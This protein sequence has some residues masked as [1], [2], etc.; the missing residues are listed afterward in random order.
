MQ[1]QIAK[2]V[3]ENILIH[4]QP[5][6]EKKDLSQITS[7][8]Y[9]EAT[10]SNTLTVK[11]TDFEI[12]L[13]IEAKGIHVNEP[14]MAT[15]NGKKLL[16]IVRIL[17]D[18]DLDLNTDNGMLDIS[19]GNSDFQLPMYN[20][21]EYPAFAGIEN[22]PGIEIDSTLLINSLKKITPAADTNNPKFE[23]NGALIDFKDGQ[24]NFVA[25][26]T[27]RLAIISIDQPS[28]GSELSLIIPKKAIIEIQKLF[29]SNID[30]YYDATHLLIKSDQY[31]FF[32]K[33][34]NGK[35]PDYNRIIPEQTNYN[36]SLP[37]NEFVNAVKQI[38]T[39]SSDMKLTFEANKIHFESL[40]DENN[41][42]T[43]EI[44]TETGITSPLT[45]AV[46]SRYLLDFLGQIEQPNFTIGLN[47][48]NLPFL[49]IE[50]DFK[51][52]VMPIVI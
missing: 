20:A 2:A 46:N 44:E 14:G 23:L 28:G 17:K 22:K 25:T 32:T 3:L 5:F 13:V 43:T 26:D 41:K 30:I 21:R 10:A 1:I 11:A 48:P 15:A 7:H 45:L 34:I 35:F 39:I 6:L 42:A 19:Q 8:L 33:L 12:G 52:I 51:T 9:F 18:G 37:K 40:S 50:N 47:E 27:R 29:T 36:L 16:D 49:L 31:T 4:A 24:I 38:T